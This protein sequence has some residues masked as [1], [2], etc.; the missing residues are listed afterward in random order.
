V[1]VLVVNADDF[2]HSEAVDAGVVEAHEHGI[3]TSASL[4]VRRS[5][6]AAAASYA[7]AHPSLGLG[8]HVELGEWT[9]VDGDWVGD[10]V[11]DDRVADEAHDQLDR[12]REL[13]GRAP[14]HLDSHQHVHRDE[15]ARSVLLE[16]GRELGVPVRHLTPEVTYC[17]GFYGQDGKG[18]PYPENVS[19]DSLVELLSLIGDG[20]TELCCHPARGR[21]AGSTYDV[22][23]ELEL[24]A[25]CDPRVRDAV[26]R[27]GILLRTFAGIGS[28]YLPA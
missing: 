6:A 22:E 12:F 24:A 21:V 5:N 20:A 3:V 7:S 16:L 19:A 2:G 18:R 17:G 14:T 1:K 15:P 9:Y 26:E 23:R 4:M 10:S 28:A 11:P 25:L 8:L 27:E 13:V